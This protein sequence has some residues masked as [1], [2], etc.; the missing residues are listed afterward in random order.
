MKYILYL[1]VLGVL[2]TSVTSCDS[3]NPSSSSSTT[4]ELEVTPSKTS[5]GIYENFTIKARMTNTP[6]SDVYLK[7]DY[8]NG[9]VYNEMPAGQDR[10]FSYDKTGTYT[11]TVTAFDVYTDAQLA[12]KTITI[13]VSDVIPSVTFARDVIDTTLMTRG[14]GS[15]GYITFSYTTNAPVTKARYHYGDGRVDSVLGNYPMSLSYES[16]GTYK[17]IVDVYNDKGNY[18]AS[19]T[20]TVIIRL[21][22]V[23]TAMLTSAYNVSVSLAVDGTSPIFASI[24]PYKHIDVGIGAQ[25]DTTNR[26]KLTWSGNSFDASFY[27]KPADSGSARIEYKFIGT[28]SSDLKQLETMTVSVYDSTYYTTVSKYGYKL[29][30]LELCGMNDEVVIYRAAYRPLTTFASDEYLT[31]KY[32]SDF[33][34]IGYIS[35]MLRRCVEVRKELPYAYVVF[36][37]K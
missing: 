17:V 18:W 24:Q 31:V 37:R 6:L 32:I 29:S 23:T 36:T 15:L 3:N 28:L 25:N 12:T 7:V 22:G 35:T 30:N 5:V 10:G 26:T 11:V 20:M 9:Q 19:D 21:P 33:D 1:L 34:Q 2:A 16:A 14:D 4:K 13:I 8:G 27:Y